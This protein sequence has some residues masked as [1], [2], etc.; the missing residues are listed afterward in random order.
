MH[1]LT[2]PITPEDYAENV[3]PF[4]RNMEANKEIIRFEQMT[5]WKNLKAV[6][7]GSGQVGTCYPDF[8]PFTVR[9]LRRNFGLYIL[10]RI[11]PSP[12]VEKKFKPQRIDR[13]KKEMILFLII[14]YLMY[15]AVTVAS[16]EF[17]ACQIPCIEPPSHTKH[18]SW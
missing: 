11:S 14:F 16:T 3:L 2:L 1:R 4:S 5:N 12:R 18:P 13:V 8:G 15:I 17:L 6:L 7:S 10:H 9:E